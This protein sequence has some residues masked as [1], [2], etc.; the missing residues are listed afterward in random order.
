M[1]MRDFLKE[2]RVFL[3]INLLLFC[4]G[5]G[6]MVQMQVSVIVVLLAF[7]IWFVPIIC[8]MSRQFFKTSKFLNELSGICDNLDKKY[9]L[10]EVINKPDYLEGK[11]FYQILK[12]TNRSMLENVS[13]YQQL[14]DE[15]RE[16]IETWVHEIKTPIGSVKLLIDNHKSPVTRSID[17]EMK[18]ID[19]YVEQAL[20]YSKS[21]H[22]NE[23]YI[24]KECS[25]KKIV[26]DT[27]TRN[28]RDLIGKFF[29]VDVT[30]VEQT[31]YSDSKWVQF[32]LNQI[33]SNSIK[34]SKEEKPNIR[35]YSEKNENNIVLTIE[36]N[37]IGIPEKDQKKVFQKGFTGENGR[38]YGK[39]TGIGLY[40]CKKLCD[41]LEI[42][43]TL[44]SE[45]GKGT[46]IQLIFSI[47]K[48]NT[49]T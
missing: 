23:D 25:L 46:T 15:Y 45:V 34:Y 20:Y 21:N 12:Q 48:H 13:Y 2:C 44:K 16:Y 5:A 30:D 18:K 1:K 32:I 10:S 31:I 7:L 49:L 28:S 22:A 36:D 3:I 8:Y 11:I 6:V 42:G 38:R 39:S 17:S 19:D 14:Q 4:I 27:I 43:I 41:Q 24:I 29:S 40:L 37:G 26:M 35:I 33:I 47:G 9:L